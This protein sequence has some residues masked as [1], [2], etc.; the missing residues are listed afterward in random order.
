MAVSPFDPIQ[1]ESLG[2]HSVDSAPAGFSESGFDQAAP[3]EEANSWFA[4]K[5]TPMVAG[6]AVVAGMLLAVFGMSATSAVNNPSR[7][8]YPEHV[9]AADVV[10]GLDRDM[11]VVADELLSGTPSGKLEWIG[12]MRDFAFSGINE[13]VSEWQLRESRIVDEDRAFRGYQESVKD[14]AAILEL[15]STPH[16][17]VQN[18]PYPD[19]Y[20]TGMAEPYSIVMTTRFWELFGTRRDEL[21]FLI[22][23]ELGHLKCDHVRQR[24]LLAFFVSM[25]YDEQDES[26]IGRMMNWIIDAGLARWCHETEKSA[27]R[28][29]LICVGAVPGQPEFNTRVADAALIR[30]RHNSTDIEIDPDVHWAQIEQVQQEHELVSSLYRAAGMTPSLGATA[31]RRRDLHDWASTEYRE[32]LKR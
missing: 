20:V 6:V 26:T 10:S 2:D 4:A 21:R 1:D 15:D 9:A 28:C 17:Y 16:M 32:L 8:L 24:S 11:S 7:R 27:D 18:S 30:L 31:D 3:Q 14:C 23:R 5:A 29:G 25:I 22:G 13:A 12:Q 19:I